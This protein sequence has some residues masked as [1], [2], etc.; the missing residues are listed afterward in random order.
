MKPNMVTQEKSMESKVN[1][2]L[3]DVISLISICT[4]EENIYQ[5]ITACDL[6]VG[7]VDPECLY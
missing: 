3:E 2:T 5:F 6:V 4:G 1:I 7:A